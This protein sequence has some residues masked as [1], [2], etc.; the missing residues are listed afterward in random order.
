MIERVTE[1]GVLF[2]VNSFQA[3]SANKKKKEQE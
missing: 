1:L 2:F 3:G